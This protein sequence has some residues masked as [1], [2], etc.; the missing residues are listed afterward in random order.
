MIGV[1]ET[2]VGFGGLAVGIAAV[3]AASTSTRA[4]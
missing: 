3:S 1:E 2:L 4:A